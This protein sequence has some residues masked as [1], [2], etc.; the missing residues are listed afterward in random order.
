VRT[1][2]DSCTDAMGLLPQIS[3]ALRGFPVIR[4]PGGASLEKPYDCD[5]KYTAC[6]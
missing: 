4:R 1:V 3:S 2:A 6:G 5:F